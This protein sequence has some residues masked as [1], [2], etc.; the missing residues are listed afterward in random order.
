MNAPVPHYTISTQPF[1]KWVEVHPALGISMMDHLFNRLDGAYP[2]KWRSNFPNQQ[3]I[4]NWCESWA[5][6]F[7]EEGITPDDVKA[8]LKA[9]RSRYDWPPS[10]AEFIKACKPSVAPLVAY[11]EASAG[12][13][14]RARGEIGKWSHP[15]IY[16]S[17]VKIGAFDLK[18]QTYS[19]LKVR[20]ESALQ[21]EMDKGN[22]EPVPKPLQALPAPGKTELSREGAKHMLSKL[23]ASD[24]LKPPTDHKGWAR[25]IMER[26]ENGDRT[27]SALQVQ[28]ARDALGTARDF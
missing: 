15:A 20:W 7:E 3:A 4:D 25:N 10:C 22:W 18:N 1:S 28:F 27:P 12:M 11:Y 23:G 26:H 9:C 14:A 19:T 5:E 6:A 21:N 13:E 24:A 17:A 8:G 2:H 16:W